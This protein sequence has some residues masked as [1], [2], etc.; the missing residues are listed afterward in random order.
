MFYATT[1][2]NRTKSSHPLLELCNEVTDCK[3]S[4]RICSYYC[5]LRTFE[6]LS[7]HLWYIISWHA[8]VFY[9]NPNLNPLGLS[10]IM[11]TYL[12][13]LSRVK[14]N[15]LKSFFTLSWA[16]NNSKKGGAGWESVSLAFETGVGLTK[17]AEKV[18]RDGLRLQTL[19]EDRCKRC[20]DEDRTE[21]W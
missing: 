8:W 2:R 17:I 10:Q 20:K 1:T 13:E 4:S 7:K 3:I 16:N 5:G 11:N 18:M 19:L 15:E 12:S 6:N 21:G 14:I 9:A